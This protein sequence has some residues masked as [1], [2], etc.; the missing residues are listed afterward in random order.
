MALGYLSN[1]TKNIIITLTLCHQTFIARFRNCLWWSHKFNFSSLSPFF[2]VMESHYIK[3][4]IR[5]VNLLLYHHFFD[6]PFTRALKVFAW[7]MKVVWVFVTF[8]LSPVHEQRLQGISKKE[9]M[10]CGG[11]FSDTQFS[12]WSMIH[13]RKLFSICES[14]LSEW[15]IMNH[16]T[17]TFVIING[18]STF[19]IFWIWF[20][21]YLCFFLVHNCH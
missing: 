15:W 1:S 18:I 5:F 6:L 17:K 13:S 14:S 2:I 19:V 3:F 9:Q 21:W 8:I 7:L 4:P 10:K 12:I 20:N 11:I 16:K